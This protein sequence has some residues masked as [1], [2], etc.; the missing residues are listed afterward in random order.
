LTI[1]DNASIEGTGT[2]VL[3]PKTNCNEKQ[4]NLPPRE[5]NQSHV[6]KV[7]E[8]APPR[9]MK[10]SSSGVRT[11]FAFPFAHRQAAIAIVPVE[12]AAVRDGVVTPTVHH[13][14]GHQKKIVNVRDGDA[15]ESHEFAITVATAVVHLTQSN[16]RFADQS[17]RM[18]T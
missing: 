10:H 16:P 15:S 6:A 8:D 18:Y 4:I 14:P 9:Q 2:Q 13:M 5:E 3:Y 12:M 11:V 17:V 1:N 7:I